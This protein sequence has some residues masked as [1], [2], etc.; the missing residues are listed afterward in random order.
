MDDPETQIVR[1]RHVFPAELL[2]EHVNIILLTAQLDAAFPESGP[3]VS[4]KGG[5]GDIIVE[6]DESLKY[7]QIKPIVLAHTVAADETP[8]AKSAIEAE[9]QAQF[10]A[11]IEDIKKDSAA[12]NALAEVKGLVS[13]IEILETK[14]SLLESGK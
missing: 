7:D 6:I 13:R 3:L 2:S 11:V 12:L 1:A 9:K 8:E 14:I 10:E 4:K 5:T